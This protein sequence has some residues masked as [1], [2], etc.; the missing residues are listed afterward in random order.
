MPTKNN[1]EVNVFLPTKSDA[2]FFCE[3]KIIAYIFLPTKNN[4][5]FLPNKN[6]SLNSFAK[7]KYRHHFFDDQ[8][9]LAI[10]FAN[11]KY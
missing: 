4:E 8:K 2:K 6:N 7:Q 10:F 11:Q 9:S 3:P 1:A 5:I